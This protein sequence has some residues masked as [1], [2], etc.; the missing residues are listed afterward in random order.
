MA[1]FQIG[2]YAPTGAVG[3]YI[4]SLIDDLNRKRAKE[5][6]EEG[7]YGDKI[8]SDELELL[9]GAGLSDNKLAKYIKRQEIPLGGNVARELNMR[10]APKK[11][12]AFDLSAYDIASQGGKRFGLADI[13]YLRSQGLKDKA[14]K[15]YASGLDE[16]LLGQKASDFLGAASST[17]GEE[18]PELSRKDVRI[19]SLKEANRGLRGEIK[20]IGTSVGEERQPEQKDRA[21]QLLEKTITNVT[22]TYKPEAATMSSPTMLGGTQVVSPSVTYG[23]NFAPSMRAPITQKIRGGGDFKNVKISSE[24]SPTFKNIGNVSAGA[25]DITGETSTQRG[26]VDTSISNTNDGVEELIR[27]AKVKAGMKA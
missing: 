21:K 11:E 15:E 24:M 9:R 5:I 20:D 23:G 26:G 4:G 10:R 13:E 25:R 16:S 6:L 2:G 8:E 22:S 1:D 27:R 18:Q 3:G 17:G 7:E 12:K 19:Q 14:I